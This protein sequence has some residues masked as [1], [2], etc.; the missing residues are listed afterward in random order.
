[1]SKINSWLRFSLAGIL[2]SSVLAQGLSHAAIAHEM[3]VKGNVAITFHIEP[4][5]NP[6]VGQP[7][8]AW[9]LLTTKGGKIVPLSDCD[10]KLSVFSVK[11]KPVKLFDPT[12][13]STSAEKY[14]GIPGAQIT[15]PEAG[16]YELKLE[17]KAKGDRD[18]Q[19]FSVIFKVTA[20]N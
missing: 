2:F 11:P 15:F 20:T 8:Q 3:E 1:M 16:L 13:T 4:K 6:K 18:F 14:Q 10:C 19:P 5:H 7:S 17:G 9:F 12:L